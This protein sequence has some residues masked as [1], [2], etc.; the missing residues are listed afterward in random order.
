M[1]ITENLTLFWFAVMLT[2]EYKPEFQFR[3]G[4]KNAEFRQ[5]LNL[6][7]SFVM[8][9]ADAQKGLD[10][11]LNSSRTRLLVLFTLCININ[12]FFSQRPARDCQ[13]KSLNISFVAISYGLPVM[14]LVSQ[15]CIFCNYRR[16]IKINIIKTCRNGFH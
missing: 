5:F 8:S 12:L 3:K 2:N 1:I 16:F 7:V 9:R 15:F 4:P 14:N 10:I 6:S 11:N 13:F